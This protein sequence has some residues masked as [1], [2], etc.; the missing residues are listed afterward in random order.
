MSLTNGICWGGV[1]FFVGAAVLI[2]LTAE[3]LKQHNLYAAD[4]SGLL[5]LSE[6]GAGVELLCDMDETIVRLRVFKDGTGYCIVLDD[7]ID[8]QTSPAMFYDESSCLISELR[9]VAHLLGAAK[10]ASNVSVRTV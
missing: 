3:M 9:Y 10:E 6:N 2:V 4:G 7:F 8:L 5:D 1:G